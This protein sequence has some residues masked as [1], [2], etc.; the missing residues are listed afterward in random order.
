MVQRVV[1][2]FCAP[3]SAV[4]FKLGLHR[5]LE[6]LGDLNSRLE[7]PPEICTVS[8]GDEAIDY[9]V[10]LVMFELLGLLHLDRHEVGEFCS[11]AHPSSS[12]FP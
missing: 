1:A 8:A 9:F 11:P 2:V 6:N 3:C 4:G 5:Q 7:A 10:E 12:A